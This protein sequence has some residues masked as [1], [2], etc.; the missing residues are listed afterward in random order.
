MKKYLCEAIAG[1]LV[2]LFVLPIAFTQLTKP[3]PRRFSG[4]RLTETSYQEVDFH[5][6]SQDIDLAGMLF[7]PTIPGPY[8]AAV[9]IQGSGRSYRQGIWYLTLTEYLRRN[10]ILVL[11]PDKRGSEKS[12]GDWRTASMHDLATDTLAAI[13]YLRSRDDIA[14]THIGVIG[15][16][17]GGHIA[18]LVANESA[19]V[20]FVVNVVGA[21]VPTHE[22]LIFEETHN[23][24]QI[25]ILPGLA[26]LL[27]YPS[28]W[29]I[30][31]IRRKEY[32]DVV[33]NSDPA[34]YWRKLN[35]R[36]L[37]LYGKDDTNVPSL[38]SER[39]LQSLGNPH[40]EVKVY[41]G[42]GHALETP[43][44]EGDSIFRE[45]AMRTIR[46]FIME[47]SSV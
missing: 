19:D 13:E 7:T 41:D 38:A 46:D 47:A 5:N 21:A 43:V 11:L 2:L 30:R 20:S 28:T 24:E 27:A 44:G 22:Q 33:G 36:G 29:V 32:W 23:L 39:V 40:I 26:H 10:G 31:N 1:T 45:D 15:M 17:Q 12:A 16:S 18:P 8:P 25:G 42:S 14:V 37:A 6:V 4:V 3:E 9:I 34:P 35:V